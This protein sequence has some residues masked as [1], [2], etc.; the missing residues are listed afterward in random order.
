MGIIER[1]NSRYVANKL[2]V[3]PRIY[4]T[5]DDAFTALESNEIEGFLHPTNE[6]R[7]LLSAR[8][9]SQLLVLPT[10]VIRGFVGFGLNKDLDIETVRKINSELIK[11]IESPEWID[12]ARAMDDPQNAKD[13][14]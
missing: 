9:D 5:P 14:N 3:M 8:G 13:A 11:I 1:P 2:G 6:L 7:S 4:A 10:E 12:T